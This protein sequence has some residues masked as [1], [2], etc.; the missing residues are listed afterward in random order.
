VNI[1]L[2]C[3]QLGKSENN[4]HI[5]V[6]LWP[7]AQLCLSPEE[8]QRFLHLINVRSDLGR[9]RAWLRAAINERTLETYLHLILASTKLE[10]LYEPH[11]Y[12]LDQERSSMLPIMAAGLCSILFSISLDS[13]SLNTPVRTLDA[14]LVA[15]PLSSGPASKLLD[16]QPNQ[17]AWLVS[18]L[19]LRR[20]GS[21]P[22][23]RCSGTR[24]APRPRQRLPS[25]QQPWSCLQLS[26]PPPSPDHTH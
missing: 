4:H 15:T 6:S 1:C 19:T 12:L 16:V 9:G 17:N 3:R 14:S 20:R 22:W 10:S 11:S 7:L 24:A 2:L 25:R 5:R 8:T 23:I 26:P 13:D 21:L 18:A